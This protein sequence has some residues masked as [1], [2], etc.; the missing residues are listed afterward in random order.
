MDEYRAE[1]GIPAA[2]LY[3]NDT[4]HVGMSSRFPHGRT[5]NMIKLLLELRA[6]LKKA[7]TNQIEMP[8][9]DNT[10]WFSRRM[11]I[12]DVH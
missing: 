2:R 3:E 10:D 4:I 12:D 6:S 9:I 8:C 11:H 1:I 7:F 5:A